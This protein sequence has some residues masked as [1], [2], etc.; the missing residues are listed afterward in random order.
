MK[1]TY[2]INNSEHYVNFCKA[3][4]ISIISKSLEKIESDKNVLFIYDNNVDKY[5]V[6]Q[7]YEELKLS[8]CNIHNLKCE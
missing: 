1:L 3:N 2:K 8:G 6:N 4:N 7:I 5:L